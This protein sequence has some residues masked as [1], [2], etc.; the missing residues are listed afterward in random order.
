MAGIGGSKVDFGS[1]QEW[2]DWHALAVI[3]LAWWN[4]KLSLDAHGVEQG[5]EVLGASVMAGALGANF[6][7]RVD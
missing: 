7:L 4:G 6:V 3:G 1:A 5:R 2:H